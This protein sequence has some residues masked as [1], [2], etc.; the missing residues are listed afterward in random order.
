MSHEYDT[1]GQSLHEAVAKVCPIHGVVIGNPEDRSTYEIQP[2]DEATPAQVEAAQQ[3]VAEFDPTKPPSTGSAL[4]VFD[5]LT[6]TEQIALLE[7]AGLG[8]PRIAEI[9]GG[10]GKR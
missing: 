5:V 2:T 4:R 9:L 8:M 7:A 10:I 1:V 6:E 3:V